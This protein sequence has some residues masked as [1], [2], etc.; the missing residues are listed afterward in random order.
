MRKIVAQL[1]YS[2]DGVVESPEKWVFD[3]VDEEAG[4]FVDQLTDR[5]DAVLLGRKTYDAWSEYWPNSDDG[6][7]PFINN[8]QKYV[9]STSLEAVGWQNATLFNKNIYENIAELKEKPGKDIGIHGSITLVRTLLEQ[10]LIDELA[11]IVFP[12]MAGEGERLGEGLAVTHKLQLANIERTQKGV[13]L[14]TY[15]PLNSDQT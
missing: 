7:A 13:L 14:L 3:L 11:L 1:F 15:R 8:V 2:L 9:I 6:F 5:Q 10:G 12:V 4:G